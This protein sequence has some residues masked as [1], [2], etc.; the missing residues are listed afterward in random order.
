[1]FPWHDFP[2]KRENAFSPV[3]QTICIMQIQRRKAND[4]EV[5]HKSNVLLI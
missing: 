1:M 5:E 4:L 2:T 3:G